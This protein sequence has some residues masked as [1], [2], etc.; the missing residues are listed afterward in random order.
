[1]TVCSKERINSEDVV[2]NR[3]NRLNTD[4]YSRKQ[5]ISSNMAV[6][7]SHVGR[8]HVFLG[9]AVIT[10]RSNYLCSGSF[11]SG[12]VITFHHD[13]TKTIALAHLDEFTNI[14]N[15]EK[16]LACFSEKAIPINQLAI[17]IFGGW[18]NDPASKRV[19]TQ[20]E[21]FFLDRDLEYDASG[22][23]LKNCK[24]IS[25]ETDFETFADSLDMADKISKAVY[26]DEAKQKG[27]YT[28]IDKGKKSQEAYFKG[29]VISK[30]SEEVMECA[31]KC[32]LKIK[33]SK[34]FKELRHERELGANCKINFEIKDQCN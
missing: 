10:N 26:V 2:F 25:F 18:C 23:Y 1:M 11:G 17:K 34:K 27:Y 15:I 24:S 9:Q 6:H 33:I 21:I 4:G 13:Q 30:E 32:R 19:G 16:I 8:Q 14:D 20:I 12:Y 29:I 7:A 5:V 28:Y 31:G 3:I 22:M